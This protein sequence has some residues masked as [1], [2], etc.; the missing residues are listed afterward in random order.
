[1]NELSAAGAK[2]ALAAFASPKRAIDLARFFQT[3]PGQYGE[4]D[5]FIGCT[6]PQSRE[7]AK[8]FKDLPAADIFELAQSEIHEHR[9]CALHIL[10]GQFKK[11]KTAGTRDELFDLWM[12]LL[13]AGKINNWDL[14]DTSAPYL[15]SW[16]SNKPDALQRLTE[17]AAH[18]DL[19]HRRA[20]VI[21]TFALIR[22]GRFDITL[23]LCEQLLADKHD[24][25]HKATGW[26]L[27]EVGNRDI[28]VLRGFLTQHAA[29]MPRTMLRYAIEK[30]EPS[31]RAIWMRKRSEQA[32]LGA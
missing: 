12:R 17:L 18:E 10:V 25:I 20:A 14:I 30:L 16:W 1:M 27:R 21:F 3:A 28:E 31:E 24:L 7:V 11:A 23:V 6:V 13:D 8:Q 5:K 2:S 32:A 22:D 15:G 29:T 9:L 4:G 19:W 26:M